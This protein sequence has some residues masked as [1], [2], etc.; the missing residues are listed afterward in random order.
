MLTR[1]EIDGF[2]SFENFAL[3][4]MPFTAII[5]PNASGKSNLFDALGLLSRMAA[6]QDIE[7]ALAG[8]RGLPAEQFRKM[9]DAQ[10]SS[11]IRLAAEVLLADA[12]SDAFGARATLTTRRIRYEVSIEWGRAPG[13]A[14]D[15]PYVSQESAIPIDRRN[16]A[17]LLR[18][19]Q[20]L[21]HLGGF[22]SSRRQKPFLATDRIPGSTIVLFGRDA[23]PGRLRVA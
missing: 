22:P 7:Q 23:K 11:R 21:K 16:D 4:L 3:D 18:L 15:R 14:M 13:T 20:R 19:P 9:P 17:W 8:D 1:I 6:G 12:A 2:K 10:P 5:G